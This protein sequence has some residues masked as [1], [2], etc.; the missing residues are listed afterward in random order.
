MAQAS[1]NTE[2]TGITPVRLW[3]PVVRLLHWSLAIAVIGAWILGEFGP[4]VMTLHFYFG[5]AALGIVALRV[6]W[7][8]VGTKPAR[9]A[10]FAYGPGK[11]LAYVR[12]MFAK[13]P[14]YWPGHNP[15]GGW[16]VFAL[17]GIVLVQA[18]T[19]LF[20]D[21][22]DFINAGPLASTVN[23]A[24]NRLFTQIHAI[25]SKLVLLIVAVHLG[26]VFFYRFY[27][28]ENLVKPMI[29]GWKAVR[30]TRD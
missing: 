3:D 19:G 9:F 21:A 6:I 2:G 22:D 16:A 25:A 13:K 15:L 5:Y 20:V 11:V 24:T 18:G 10:S 27:K 28:G 14:S 8:F 26:A 29:T 4:N 30:Q 23:S 1:E 7:G 17:L 12:G